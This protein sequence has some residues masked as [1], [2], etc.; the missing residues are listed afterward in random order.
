MSFLTTRFLMWAIVA[1]TTANVGQHI[2]LQ[3]S[4]SKVEK[5]D[6]QIL[7]LEKDVEMGKIVTMEQ[8]FDIINLK[9]SMEND[10][11]TCTQTIDDLV[12]V[13]EE[14]MDR[15]QI[16]NDLYRGGRKSAFPKSKTKTNVVI[17]TEEETNEINEYFD[18]PN[19]P[20]DVW[21]LYVIH[22]DGS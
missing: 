17:T 9:D 2:L 18:A 20:V 19:V 21:Q 22:E 14:G 11:N 13:Y 3:M 4:W 16:L 6:L 15:L 10:R 7:A 8:E 5:K 12:E 1:L